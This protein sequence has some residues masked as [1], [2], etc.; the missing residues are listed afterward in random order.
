VG[1]I[2]IAVPSHSALWIHPEVAGG[3]TLVNSQIANIQN[4][5]PQFKIL[6]E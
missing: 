1:T 2:A 3:L 4:E 5:S 6:K